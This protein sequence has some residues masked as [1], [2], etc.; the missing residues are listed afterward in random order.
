MCRNCCNRKQQKASKC[1]S[2]EELLEKCYKF[3]TY[4]KIAKEYNVSDKTI[5]K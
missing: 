5:R 4:S 1:P 2:K 3:K